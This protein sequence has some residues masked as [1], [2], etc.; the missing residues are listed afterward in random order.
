MTGKATIAKGTVDEA[1]IFWHAFAHGASQWPW[2]VW[3]SIATIFV[4]NAIAHP[5]KRRVSR[6]RNGGW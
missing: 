6:G 5:R 1:S 2:W 3:A 4:G